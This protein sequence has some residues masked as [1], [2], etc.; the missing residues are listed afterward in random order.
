MLLHGDL[1]QGVD[2]LQPVEAEILVFFQFLV[3]LFFLA[4]QDDLVVLVAAVLAD[5]VDHPLDDDGGGVV[6]AHGVNG[7]LDRFHPDQASLPLTICFPW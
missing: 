4:D 2:D 5:V 7:D 3:D 1:F 6:A